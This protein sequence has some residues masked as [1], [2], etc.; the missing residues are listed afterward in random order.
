MELTRLRAEN[1]R[2]KME[3]ELA[4]S[5]HLSEAHSLHNAPTESWWGSLK[6]CSLYGKRF[7]TSRAAI[8]EMIDWLMFYNHSRLHSSLGYMSPVQF[9]QR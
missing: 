7:S 6:V 8:D 3:R 5:R 9:E 4:F 2:L 1:A